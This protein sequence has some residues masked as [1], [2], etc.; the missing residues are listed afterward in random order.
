M[1]CFKH[2][3]LFLSLIFVLTGCATFR[4][5]EAEK[6]IYSSKTINEFLQSTNV[7]IVD[8]QFVKSGAWLEKKDIISIS[9]SGKKD[10]EVKILL[11][12]CEMEKGFWENPYSILTILVLTLGNIYECKTIVEL[13][14][15]ETDR[16]YS[17]KASTKIFGASGLAAIIRGPLYAFSIQQEK[18]TRINAL[19]SRYMKEKNI[20]IE[21]AKKFL[22]FYY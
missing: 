6:E 11:P 1:K 20:P 10:I 12:E 19:L 13:R 18:R 16:V 14:E 9:D 21:E 2:I 5:S 7:E 3:A 22:I 15:L 8:D 17:Y 4:L